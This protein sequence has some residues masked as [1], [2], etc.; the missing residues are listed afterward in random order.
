MKIFAYI[1][2]QFSGNRFFDIPEGYQIKTEQG[3]IHIQKTEENLKSTWTH[4]IG[5]AIKTEELDFKLM[6]DECLFFVNL[7]EP[8]EVSAIT[9]VVK[10]HSFSFKNCLLI[11]GIKNDTKDG[12]VSGLIKLNLNSEVTIRDKL[13]I[14]DGQEITERMTH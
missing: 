9:T 12:W 4:G 1:K 11:G 13:F 5:K 10:D 14:F 2:K 6:Q 3:I 8:K 7:R